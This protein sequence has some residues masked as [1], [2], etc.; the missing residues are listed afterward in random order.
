MDCRTFKEKHLAFVDDTLAGVEVVG[1]QLHIAE[2][3]S[4]A[5]LDVSIRRSLMLFRSLP[6]IDLSPGFGDR[7]DASIRDIRTAGLLPPAQRLLG[8]AFLVGLASAAMIGFI[9]TTLYRTDLSQDV[10]MEPVVASLPEPEPGQHITPAEAIVASAPA[11]LG[12]WSAAL[13]AEQAPVHFAH[14]RLEVASYNR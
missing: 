12:I 13:Y 11:G 8:R 2:C 6:C 1:M 7:L 4:C 3:D 10:R 14:T 9:A 5:R